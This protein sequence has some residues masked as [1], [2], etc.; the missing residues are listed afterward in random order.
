[1]KKT[2]YG[3]VATLGLALA[4]LV[5]PVLASSSSAG[6][7]DVP[8]AR[9]ETAADRSASLSRPGPAPAAKAPKTAPAAAEPALPSF[10]A[11]GLR[12]HVLRLA[13]EAAERADRQGLVE[14]PELLTVIDFSLPSTEKRLWVLDLER[15]EVLF[16]ELTTH[17]KGTGGNWA[18]EF[19]NVSMSLESNL[20]L[21]TTA[22]TY[23]G[24]NGYSLRLDGH[25]PGFN[26]QARPRA[27]VMHGADYATRAF[28]RRVGR[29][30]R[31]W[32]CPALD[33]KVNRKLIDTIK[34][35]SAIFGYYP[36]EEY[37]TRSAFVGDAGE[38]AL[39]MA[40]MR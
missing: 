32:G 23:Y 6:A 26:D 16:H 28:I 10:D 17:G 5:I 27:I 24:K 37:L 2:A 33:P 40:S 39:R 1:M 36:D 19:S 22:E 29:L 15:G 14:R 11:P 9:T 38:E 18:K 30:G 34:G 20:G 35:G 8:A 4:I 12:P 25:E 31:S 21:L 3:A 13:V 7:E